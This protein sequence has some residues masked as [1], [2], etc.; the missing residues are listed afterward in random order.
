MKKTKKLLLVF[1]GLIP[2]MAHSQSI[3]DKLK[4]L[5]R[6]SAGVANLTIQY[7]LGNYHSV[8]ADVITLTDTINNTYSV[9]S[10]ITDT[11]KAGIDTTIVLTSSQISSLN[12]FYTAAAGSSNPNPSLS[13]NGSA[14][15][16]LVFMMCCAG[17]TDVAYNSNIHIS[18]GRYLLGY[19]QNWQ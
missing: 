16:N 6:N 18:L 9:H 13:A 8:E 2:F 4:L 19:W 7:T 14:T 11:G 5:A 10:M 3:T 17:N 12:S 1:I 15:S